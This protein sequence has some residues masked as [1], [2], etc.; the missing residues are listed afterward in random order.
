MCQG[1]APPCPHDPASVLPPP[2]FRGLS[3]G[4]RLDFFLKG[5][6]T[7]QKFPP[8]R[9]KTWRPWRQKGHRQE[10]GIGV[11]AEHGGYFR[12]L[13]KDGKNPCGISYS[14]GRQ[15]RAQPAQGAREAGKEVRSPPTNLLAGPAPPTAPSA[16]WA[17]AWGEKVTLGLSRDTAV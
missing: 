12:G 5:E 1:A 16:R 7:A 4:S 13:R 14:L 11:E 9:R 10:S 3:S 2:F 17:P 15:V 6:A 8:S